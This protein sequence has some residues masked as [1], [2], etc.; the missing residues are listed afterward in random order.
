MFVT[1]FGSSSEGSMYLLKD[2][3]N[4]IFCFDI[5]INVFSTQYN[6]YLSDILNVEYL[7]ISH[8]HIDHVRSLKKFLIY[9][10]R[11]KIIINPKILEFFKHTNKPTYKDLYNLLRFRVILLE[12]GQTYEDTKIKIKVFE[13]NHNATANNGYI[14]IN[15]LNNFKILFFTDCGSFNYS[16]VN[17]NDFNNLSLCMMEINHDDREEVNTKKERTQYSNI[18]HFSR[19][20]ALQFIK[21]LNDGLNNK[22]CKYLFL[23]TSTTNYLDIARNDEIFKLLKLNFLRLPATQLKRIKITWQKNN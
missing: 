3:A 5:G 4:N 6:K 16:L 21:W 2:E 10:P 9:N 20:Q 11:A 8:E 17:K 22:K 13:V 12:H 7:F 19:F 14:F 1:S 18:G 23:H 15:K